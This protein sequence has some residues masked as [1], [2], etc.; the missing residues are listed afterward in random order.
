VS[1]KVLARVWAHSNQSGGALLVM[2]AL[3]DFANDDG[4][5]WPSIPVLAEK[6]RLTERGIQYLLPILE[7]AG[8]IRRIRS[9]GGRNRRSHYFVTVSENGE[10]VSLKEFHHYPNGEK[11]SVKSAAE[12]GEAHFTRIKPSGTVNKRESTESDKL[13]PSPV[14]VSGHVQKPKSSASPGVLGFKETMGLYHDLFLAKFGAKPDIDG[15]RDGKLLAGLV[16]SHGADQVQS[17]L[18]FFFDHPPGWVEKKGKFTLPAFKSA[19]TELL[20]QSRNG[21]QEMRA[22]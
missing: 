1:V 7:Q 3:A 21:K 22:F 4:E 2:L 17:L 18:R 11:Y 10:R 5:C 12:N 16:K 15:G 20:A 6:A 14:S 13:I 19:Y 9:T 8:E